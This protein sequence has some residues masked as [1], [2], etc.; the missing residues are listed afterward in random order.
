MPLCGL[1]GESVTRQ[2]FTGSA[3][4]DQILKILRI[5]PWLKAQTPIA[6]K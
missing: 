6:I 5:A 2:S 4:A 3:R 1:A